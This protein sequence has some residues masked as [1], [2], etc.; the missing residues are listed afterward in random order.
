MGELRA[1]AAADGAAERLIP[2]DL[3][4][5]Q[6]NYSDLGGGNCQRPAAE[7]VD[8]VHLC[9]RHAAGAR[10]SKAAHEKSE[11]KYAAAQARTAALRSQAAAFEAILGTSIGLEYDGLMAHDYT[12]RFV[13]S[14]DFLNA[15][16]K[17]RS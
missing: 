10:R 15:L 14:G 5:C 8:G 17:E 9:K 4:K 7:I 6:G 13:V 2:K 12:G 3:G 1:A 11:T 16:V